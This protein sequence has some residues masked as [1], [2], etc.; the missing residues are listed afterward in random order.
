MIPAENI[1]YEGV[2]K[3]ISQWPAAQQMALVEDVL[4]RVSPRVKPPRKRQRT[5]DRALG[6]LA[7]DQLAPTDEEFKRWL[8]KHRMVK[9]G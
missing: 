3:I 8:D 4:K 6:L 9:Y 1:G 5:I 7:T 2:L